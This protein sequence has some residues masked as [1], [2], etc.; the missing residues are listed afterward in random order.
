MYATYIDLYFKFNYPRTTCGSCGARQERAAR[1]IG[2][3]PLSD[4]HIQPVGAAPEAAR[5]SARHPSR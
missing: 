5:V 3:W 1:A 4:I 2:A